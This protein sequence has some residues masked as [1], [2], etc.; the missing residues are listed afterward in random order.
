MI[1]A[2]DGPAG[3][4]KSTTAREV[5]RRLGALYIDTG[6]M[7]RAVAL[8]VMEADGTDDV[9]VIDRVPHDVHIDLRAGDE[10]LR[11]ILNGLDVTE[12]IRR[13]EVS[14]MASRVSRYPIVREHL[15]DQQRR[16]AMD[17]EEAGRAVVM[18][19]RDIGT[20]VFPDAEYKFFLT[21]DAKVRAE[22]RAD[23]LRAK[24]EDVD[25]DA[26]YRDIVE[27]D[28]LDETREH[29]PLRRA[30]DAITIDTTGRSF[31]EQVDVVLRTIS[32]NEA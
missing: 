9:A 25:E 7:Y 32:G 18:E 24:G 13:E 30:A 22:R 3:S 16:I 6:A 11:V 21:A 31:E 1:I 12:E 2:I 23:Q 15:V 4:G 27:R 20:V 14:G 26:L 8:R 19:G 17:A 5:A 10:G 28:R 29:S